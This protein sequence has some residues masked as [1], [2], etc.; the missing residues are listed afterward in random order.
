[1]QNGSF[2][3]FQDALKTDPLDIWYYQRDA[4]VEHFAGIL[5][6][7]TRSDADSLRFSEYCKIFR[8]SISQKESA[9]SVNYFHETF[10]DKCS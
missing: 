7:K 9:Q 4:G 8:K 6:T 3:F 5:P 1:M 2:C 10:V